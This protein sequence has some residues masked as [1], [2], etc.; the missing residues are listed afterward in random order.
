[1]RVGLDDCILLVPTFTKNARMVDGSSALHGGRAWPNRFAVIYR[2][3]KVTLTNVIQGGEDVIQL[4]PPETPAPVFAIRAFKTAIFGTPQD[5]E[6][7]DV[8]TLP[9]SKEV[10]KTAEALNFADIDSI[11]VSDALSR[12]RSSEENL[13]PPAGADL[14][15]PLYSPTKPTGI[16]LTPGT[17]GNR[18]KTVSFGTSV[19]DN[20]GRKPVH[21]GPSGLPDNCPGK[22]P[23]PWERSAGSQMT[24]PRTKLTKTLF[25]VRDADA[26][27]ASGQSKPTGYSNGTVK[28]L[29]TDHIEPDPNDK[30]TEN[31]ADATIDLNDPRSRSGR[32]WKSEYSGYQKKTKEEMKRLVKY[33]QMAKSYAKKKDSEA[34]DLGEKLREERDKVKKMEGQI[35]ELA[36]QIAAGRR[37]GDKSG[38]DQAQL[39]KELARQTALAL[40]YKGKVDDF[41][42]ALEEHAPSSSHEHHSRVKNYTSPRTEKTLVQ[43][44]VELKK[45]REQLQEMKSLRGEISVHKNKLEEAE[46]KSLALE[47]ERATLQM[48]LA[49]VKEEMT[50]YEQ[51]R[52]DKQ[53]QREAKFDMERTRHKERLMEMKLE[54]QKSLQDSEMAWNEERVRLKDQIATLSAAT[55]SQ[56]SLQREDWE[57][58]SKAT[59]PHRLEWQQQQRKTLQELR[60]ARE[61]SSNLRIENEKL[62][63]ELRNAHTAN[64]NPQ[65]DQQPQKPSLLDESFLDIWTQPEVKD[66]S[67]S[68]Q[69]RHREAPKQ[70]SANE[71]APT[72]RNSA[73]NDRDMNSNAGLTAMPKHSPRRPSPSTHKPG[74]HTRYQKS[75]SHPS[76]RLAQVTTKMHPVSSLEYGD[77]PY[78]TDDSPRPSMFNMALSPPTIKPLSMPLN[79]ATIQSRHYAV[80][81]SRDAG[82]RRTVSS[83]VGSLASASGR[84]NLPPDR[85]AAAKARLE[86]KN[87]EKRLIKHSGKENEGAQGA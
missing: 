75:P 4:E 32:Y 81:K 77:L 31:E 82:I 68:L 61:E 49:R 79:T 42:A 56:S 13:A 85:V 16:L 74:D 36:S 38:P 24:R 57:V 12:R 83:R 63:I 19:V 80:A 21:D 54:Y 52:E 62:R 22:F 18:R 44:S 1:M 10:S 84:P 30:P 50:K 37:N 53:R 14:L 66:V 59:D 67:Q 25:D 26:E 51:R 34:M 48:S 64:P 29:E 70:N 76:P 2:L 69:A 7:T 78:R 35:Q 73:L 3:S 9:N 17:A 55:K 72:E 60:Q 33:K 46:K 23:S 11:K 71:E 65:D 5:T 87:A 40:E 86:Q 20:E 41:Q 45:A 28:S 6:R 47:G 43:T 39:M 8:H 15:A 27:A 58:E